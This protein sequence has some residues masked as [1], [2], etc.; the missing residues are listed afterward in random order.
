MTYREF[1]LLRP[2]PSAARASVPRRPAPSS[3]NR[4]GP[5]ATT[6]LGS[7]AKTKPP[8]LRGVEH[9]ARTVRR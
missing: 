5:T 6:S 1:L 7:E 3:G 4:R 8:L 9:R 2:A